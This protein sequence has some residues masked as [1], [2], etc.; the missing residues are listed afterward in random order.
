MK[1][2]KP[3]EENM[4]FFSNNLFNDKDYIKNT[5]RSPSAFIQKHM[6]DKY[7]FIIQH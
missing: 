1:K 5:L 4:L 3:I 2:I 7:D 6:G